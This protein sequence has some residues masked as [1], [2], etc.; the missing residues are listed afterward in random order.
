MNL[1]KS[2][3]WLIWGAMLGM[4]LPGC[5][6]Q[7]TSEPTC[8]GECNINCGHPNGG[9][10]GMYSTCWR[11]WPEDCVPCPSHALL[12]LEQ[13]LQQPE[14]IPSPNVEPPTI[15]PPPVVPPPAVPT[16]KETLPVP[17]VVPLTK[18]TLPMPTVVPLADETLPP[19]TV[20]RVSHESL[21]LPAVVPTA[22]ETLPLP[23]VVPDVDETIPLIRPDEVQSLPPPPSLYKPNMN[24]RSGS[25]IRNKESSSSSNEL[26]FRGNPSLVPDVKR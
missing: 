18:A 20:V 21:P 8:R 17:P 3:G 15:E 19:L 26:V 9:C 7:N 23:A 12:K 1:L 24:L 13:Q 2:T 16:P 6:T 22:N 10:Y 25:I 11:G 5:A 4:I 14:L